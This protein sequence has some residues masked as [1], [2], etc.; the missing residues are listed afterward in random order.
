MNIAI[1]GG[2]YAGLAAAVALADAGQAITL[3][4]ASR[5]LG[6]RARASDIAGIAL[7]NG[8]HLLIGAYRKTLNLMR[9]VGADPDRRLLRL[10][11]TLDFP[12]AVRLA[13]PRLPAPLHLAAALFGARGLTWADRYAAIRL[14]QRLKR[15]RFRLAH[16]EPVAAWLGREVQPATLCRYLWEPLCVAALNTPAT[17]ASA[18]IFA[19]VLRDGL[20]GSAADSDLLIPLADLSQ[21][22]P[23]PA[24]GHVAARGGT[25]VRGTRIERLRG[26]PGGWRLDEHGPFDRVILAV[27]PHHLSR[28]TAGLPALD[29][30][31]RQVDAF[32]YEPIVTAYLGYP[33]S[34]RL[35]QPMLGFAD[36]YLQWLFD[37]GQLGGPAGLLAAVI[38][39][40][41]RHRELEADALCAHLHGEI[42]TVLPDLP[43]PRWQRVIVEKRAT[44][45][46]T[47]GLSRPQTATPLPGL[48]LAGDYVAGDYPAT[49]EGAVRSGIA[50]ARQCMEPPLTAAE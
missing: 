33:D 46:C 41:G 26:E 13:A 9:R 35:P 29:G 42:R 22:F 40:S 15:Q 24:A 16:D 19:N 4:E 2:G 10:P 7:D 11:L 23:E 37:R 17:E 31:R 50:A 27:A 43:M 36:G 32:A 25:I 49:I 6:G 28:L 8:Q 44:F 3:F 48:F 30:L 47:P 38:S 45:A 5:T 14:M 12:G 21:L 20:C 1:V 39:A 34:V 18:Q